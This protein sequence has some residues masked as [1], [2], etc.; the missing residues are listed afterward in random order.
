[1]KA[2][3]EVF[4]IEANDPRMSQVEQLYKDLYDLEKEFGVSITLVEDGEKIWRKS[5]E[6]VL[7]KFAQ[8]IVVSLGEEIVGL[9]YGNIK[10]LPAYFG[11]IKSGYLD[12]IIIKAEHRKKGL[13]DQ[14]IQ[15]LID[16]WV[17]NDVVVFEV[18]RQ[19]TNE[20]SAK[21]WERFG[22]KKEL[23]RY[24]KRVVI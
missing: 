16:W 17:A 23:I 5:I 11:S 14:M 22:F 3:Y 18:E 10:M 19:I 13:G 9:C 24:R 8:I 21:N 2:N 12:A 4:A 1:M 15:Q 6:K 20:N 7:G